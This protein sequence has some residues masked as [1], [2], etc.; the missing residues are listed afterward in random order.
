MNHDNRLSISVD[1]ATSTIVAEGVI[2]LA[3]IPLLEQ[4]LDRVDGSA[5]LDLR[6]VPF[7]DSS[8]LALLLDRTERVRAA[9]ERLEI[10]ASDAVHAVI[11]LARVGEELD[12]ADE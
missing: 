1:E 10:R 4:A 8:G 6:A 2:D 9:G 7:M 11:E 5:L 12:L 3:G